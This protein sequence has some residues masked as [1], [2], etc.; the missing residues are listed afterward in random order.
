MRA[1]LAA[2]QFVGRQCGRLLGF[3]FGQLQWSPPAWLRNLGNALYRGT[4]KLALWLRTHPAR[5]AGVA[6]LFIAVVAAG[7]FGW[8]W[9]QHRPKPVEITFTIDVPA[10][11]CYACDA[12]ANSP[13]PL[14]VHFSGSVAPLSSSGKNVEPNKAGIDVSPAIEGIWS[15]ADDRTLKFQP[16]ADWPV[17]Q[18]YDISFSRHGFAAAH[19]RLKDYALDFKT[20]PFTATLD[21]TEFY[22]DPVNA[23][24]KKVLVTVAFSHPVDSA[25][26]SN[27]V[28]LTLFN[29]LTDAQEE[30]VGKPAFTVEYDKLKLHA[31]VH[32]AQLAV[33][34]KQGRLA[35]EIASGLRAARGGN[36]TAEPLK[37]STV[38]PGQ[39]A[40]TVDKLQFDIARDQHDDPRQIL[41]LHTSYSVTE[42]E[43]GTKVEAWLLPL[44]TPDAKRQAQ[45]EH[46]H[47]KHPLPFD[48]TSGQNIT[49]DLLKSA[50]PLPL[51][52]TPNEQDHVEDHSFGYQAEPGRYVYVQID[53][54]LRS[55][56]GYQLGQSLTQ[57]LRVPEFPKELRIA[58]E[59]SLLAM[60]GS[61]K[62]T[63]FSRD[64]PG[65]QIEI[66]RLLPD[67]LQ[68]LVSQ[69]NGEFNKPEFRTAW[70]FDESNITERFTKV[71]RLPK[72]KPGTAHYEAIDLGEYL[73][74]EGS[75]RRG[76]FLLKVQAYDPDTK[77]VLGADSGD[78]ESSPDTEANDAPD[79]A[80]DG[81]GDGEAAAS[82]ASWAQASD[83]RL[84]VVTDL[85]LLVKKTIDG[86]QDVFVQ[87]IHS[88]EPVAGVSLSVMGKN[89]EALQTQTT[90]VD[91]HAR[92]ADLKSFKREH[93]PVLYLARKGD[94]SSFLPIGRYD[95]D[96][97]LSRFDI[98]GVRNSADSG[99]LSAFLFSDR[100]I[101]RPG[102]EIRLG[103]I[104]KTQDWSH[105]LNG[106]PLRVQITDPRGSIVRRESIR[107][108]AAG[109]EDI[110]YST[111]ESSPT[112]DYVVTLSIIKS[113][114]R[115]DAIGSITVKVQEFQPDRLRMSAHLSADS[116]TGWVSPE[117]LKASIDLQNLF[118]TAAEN[119]RV[120]AQMTLSPSFPA[121]SAY[122][123]FQ[124]HDPQAAKEGFS[125]QLAEAKTDDKGAASFDLNLQRFTRA[126]YRLHFV[127]EGFEADGGRGVAAEAAQLVSSL[128][129]LVGWK[130]DGALDF[131][132]R[133]AQRTVDLVAID[134]QAKKIEVKDLKLVKIERRYV[135]VL[136]KLD[137]GVYKY[138]SKL[139]EIT[140][141]E[142]AYPLPASGTK[143]ALDTHT[144]G[145]FSVVLQDGAG[146]QYARI[147]YSVAGEANLAGR[148]DKN[149]ELQLILNA[150][151]YAPGDDIAIQV[152]AP[153]TGSGLI[154]IERDKVYAYKWF[155]ATTTSS[156]QH[157]KLPAG[158]DGNAYVSVSF[159]RDP[160]SD[161]IYTS[162]LSYGVQPFSVALDH[163][164]AQVTLD[165]PELVKPGQRL[166]IHYK[167][168]RPTRIV[169][170]AI[171]EGILQVAR[172]KTPAPLAYFF[173][174]HSLDVRTSQIL[175]QILP[176]FMHDANLAAPGGD[177]EG[178]LGR[179]LN[180]FKRKT[181]KPV[182]Y[183]SGIVD[184]D[185]TLRE[186]DYEVPDYFNGSLR[187]MAV[188]VADGAVGV[189]EGKTTVRGDFVLSP[190]APTTVTPGD[191][192]DVSV[193]VANNVKGSGAEAPV[194]ISV[195]PSSQVEIVGDRQQTVKITEMHE[196]VAHFRVRARDE[197]GSATLQFKAALNDKSTQLATTLSVRPAMP[198]R[199]ELT[200]GSFTRSGQDIA[201]D[202]SL[203]PQYRKLEAGVSVLP[204]GLAHGLVS[205]L[206]NYAYDCTEQLA[207]MA[208]PAIVLGNRP[209]FGYVR[210]QKGADLA[211]LVDELRARQTNEGAYRYWP[212]QSGVVEFV[213]LYAQQALLEANERG[214]S[215][216]HDLIEHGN[217]Y[218]HQLAARDG[219]N[220]GEERD[221][222]YA[223]YLLTRQGNVM[224]NEAAA[225]QGRLDERYKDW[226][227]DITA[228]YL[229]S[230]YQLM[231]QQRLADKTIAKVKLGALQ[232][233]DAYHS[234]MAVDAELLY[235][236]ARHFPERTKALP[237]DFL[238][239]LV[240]RL[241]QGEF[242]SLS[243]AEVILALDQYANTVGTAA[244]GKLSISEVLKDG[245]A[246]ALGLP[247]SVL[248]KT[249]FTEQAAG[250]RFGNDADVRA[251]YEV[252]QSG[253]DRKPPLKAISKGFE[254][255]RE[256][257]DTSGKPA[258]TVKLGEELEVHVKFRATDDKPFTNGVL[259]D[260]LPGGFEIVLPRTEPQQQALQ[261]ASANGAIAE[262]TEGEGEA[263]AGEAAFDCGC[264]FFWYHPPHFPDYADLREDRVVAYGGISTD[265]QELRYRIKAT[266]VGTFNL[267]PAYGEAMYDRKVQAQSLAGSITVTA[268]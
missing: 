155:K 110:R 263:A 150:K 104:V 219:N 101:Y 208:M 136:T 135:S 74:K 119:R 209:E 128:P 97:D 26:F 100:G 94:D 29:K 235:L 239:T 11:T 98:G 262:G 243:A 93:E 236:L 70:S 210:T 172:Y 225:L 83:N 3:L 242:Y 92:F 30:E 174:K 108:S 213:S 179:H 66:A 234:P 51:S 117:Q 8:R 152:L 161:E 154:T 37:S 68:H 78:A 141:G 132:A 88:G 215:V 204:L 35:V 134:S 47:K 156:V 96:L 53:K 199:T 13:K 103:A 72:L 80:D 84:V 55:F 140:L 192:F 118:G 205:Y 151:D 63:V 233:Y 190:N 148:L 23:S 95:R 79:Q 124:F 65:V 217:D 185:T 224:A 166:V 249:A 255:V 163:R 194:V 42:K 226:P 187:V 250:L 231:K 253:F 54:G 109:F 157:I 147:D 59:G 16:A 91:G 182:A 7:I 143:L 14:V 86:S 43:I 38:V 220:L 238:D 41:V 99:R 81:E 241:G 122:P 28:K 75:D 5:G 168:D 173:Q 126:T 22:Q 21:S 46:D 87:S 186:V 159:I 77:K 266:N 177:A 228:A 19:V 131:V 106:V 144:P 129:Y 24:D 36:K 127:A 189:A 82:P 245:S 133:D 212:G 73:N 207:S 115:E 216:P 130:A 268:P 107:L 1:L 25:E 67:Q 62:L 149:A 102:D 10:L 61:K 223:I 240:K 229:A 116:A 254:I 211:G 89:G 56:G 195:D 34:A 232:S 193:G 196:G 69:T 169:I 17:A 175:D 251:F 31:Y 71:I 153:Y 12:P 48:W 4:R 265:V 247:D 264:A 181:D 27:R 50:E 183:W 178:A 258:T 112:G 52:Y 218:L 260:L 138:V 230:A 111:R 256:Y 261:S 197:L 40:L 45:W 191:E 44:K 244:A 142:D 6:L 167:T 146:Q 114:G 139:K 188:A 198:Y 201:I 105:T 252:D 200:V 49:P 120:T 90:D 18:S 227:Q 180:P 33:P 85:G 2:I 113:E 171:D 221:T 222:A 145:S 39:F 58:H 206:G 165:K 15:W 158:I 202:R 162:P 121:F 60:S 237:A 248:P 164:T 160:A 214:Q 32:S 9:Y 137:S 123:N 57:T 257:T 267:P 125:D 176:E 203:Y 64:V 259:V 170:F 184:A 246:R 76:V 20:P